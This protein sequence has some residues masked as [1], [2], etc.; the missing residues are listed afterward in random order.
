[1]NIRNNTNIFESKIYKRNKNRNNFRVYDRFINLNQFENKEQALNLEFCSEPLLKVY[2][3][4]PNFR[5][6]DFL[7][8]THGTKQ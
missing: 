4:H 8:R 1:M 6:H 3:L 2:G 5:S 7:H